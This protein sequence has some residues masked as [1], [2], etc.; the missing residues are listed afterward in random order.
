MGF[1]TCCLLTFLAICEG[2]SKPYCRTFAALARTCRRFK[3]PALNALWKDMDD[4]MPL[5]L[6]LPED[7]R[8]RTAVNGGPQIQWVS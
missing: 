2:S 7:V 5:V 1:K 3:E 4:F 6:C 8:E